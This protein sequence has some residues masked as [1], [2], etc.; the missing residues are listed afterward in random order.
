MKRKLGHEIVLSN[1]TNCGPCAAYPPVLKRAKFAPTQEEEEA[2]GVGEFV[3][4]ILTGNDS[5]SSMVHAS[6]GSQGKPIV[7]EVPKEQGASAF[8]TLEAN[9]P[10][11][12]GLCMTCASPTLIDE[13]GVLKSPRGK[14]ANISLFERKVCPTCATYTH[15]LHGHERC[16]CTVET[17]TVYCLLQ[18]HKDRN[19]G[20]EA[21]DEIDGIESYTPSVT[22][23][24]QG[25][26]DACIR[27]RRSSQKAY[28]AR[29]ANASNLIGKP[30]TQTFKYLNICAHVAIA[31]E[32]IP[33]Q[34]HST[35]SEG[36]PK[37]FEYVYRFARQN[38]KHG[39]FLKLDANKS[40]LRGLEKSAR[41][42][43]IIGKPGTLET[44]AEQLLRFYRLVTQKRV[45]ARIEKS[46]GRN[47]KIDWTAMGVR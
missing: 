12:Y 7:P 40:T 21:L 34:R 43:N 37:Q 41:K 4:G 9:S 42:W 3:S 11:I 16:R 26:C 31:P 39:E 18:Q 46:R 14:N 6:D 33:K 35:F 25:R 22:V 30:L 38:K 20:H 47:K 19:S 15:C 13:L 28:R 23:D 29:V 32:P 24:P 17:G 8:V 5:N 2:E 1:V 45:A 10:P 44:G 36:T 27:Q